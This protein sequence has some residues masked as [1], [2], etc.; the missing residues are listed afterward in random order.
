MIACLENMKGSM[1]A[2]PEGP[3]RSTGCLKPHT[4]SLIGLAAPR[5]YLDVLSI[6]EK[7]MSAVNCRTV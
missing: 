6:D 2:G 1:L 5:H 3:G 7:V 4:C